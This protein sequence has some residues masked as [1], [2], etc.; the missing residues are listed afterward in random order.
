M[1]MSRRETMKQLKLY[2]DITGPDGNIFYII[3]R[4]R[5]MM[6]RARRFTEFN[7]LLEE[8]H[9][10]SYDQALYRIDKVVKLIDTS[11]KQVLNDHIRRGKQECLEKR[12]EQ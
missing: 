8:I 12:G 9:K 3:G 4:V 7:N 11:E 2:I 6:R 5:E 10:G 1:C